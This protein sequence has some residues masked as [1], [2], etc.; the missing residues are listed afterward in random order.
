MPSSA[1]A[2]GAAR[3][4]IRPKRSDFVLMNV[5]GIQLWPDLPAPGI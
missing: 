3:A 5:S 4:R 2:S 1:R